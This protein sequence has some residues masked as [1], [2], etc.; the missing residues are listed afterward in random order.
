MPT[1]TS[2]DRPKSWEEVLREVQRAWAESYVIDRQKELPL[3]E[4]RDGDP[5]QHTSAG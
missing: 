2:V 3:V 4:R 5:P 1:S